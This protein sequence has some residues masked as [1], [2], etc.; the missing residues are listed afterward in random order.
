MVDEI[1]QL[2]RELEAAVQRIEKPEKI[3]KNQTS[4]KLDQWRLRSNPFQEWQRSNSNHRHDVSLH[5]SV[6]NR[7]KINVFNGHGSRVRTAEC[8]GR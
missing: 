1:P 5:P 7:L 4:W 3:K 2:V 8:F 6:P